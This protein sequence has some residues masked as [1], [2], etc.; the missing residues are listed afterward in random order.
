MSRCLNAAEGAVLVAQKL[1]L[2]EEI[3]VDIF[4]GKASQIPDAINVDLIAEDG[5][6]ASVSDLPQIFPPGSVSEIIASGPQA[7]FLE[8][9]ALVLKPGGRIYINATKGN[10]YGKIPDRETRDKLGSDA[11]EKLGFRVVR[12]KGEL[13]TRFAEHRFF[14]TSGRPIP[15]SS[16]QTTIL[17]KVG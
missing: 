4:G 7:P 2:G 1:A 6:R 17:E 15:S 13:E 3:I 5:I 9:A 16:V 11:L 14:T 12:E 8:E 10:P